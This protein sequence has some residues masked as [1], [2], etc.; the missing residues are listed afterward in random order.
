MRNLCTCQ[1][2]VAT[3]R[4]F[5][6]NRSLNYDPT[7]TLRLRKS[8]AADATRRFNKLKRDIRIS[9]IDRDCFG[10]QPE[11]IALAATP[12][13]AFDFA[14]TSDKIEGFMRWLVEQEEA[15]IL[16]I[17]RRP[18]TIR[19]IEE[20]WTDVYIQSAYAKGLVRGRTELRKQGLDIPEAEN[21]GGVR[22]LMNQ[23]FHADRVG[24]LYTRVFEDLK[25]VTQFMN[26]QI[27]RRITEG[28]TTGLAQGMAEGKNPRQIARELVKNVNDRVDKIGIT[29][30]RL[31]ARTEV[32]RA[33]HVANIAEYERAQELFDVEVEV[34][35]KAEWATAGFNVCPI[36]IDLE[37]GSPYKLHEIRG[38]IPA[39]PNCRCAALPLVIEKEAAGRRAA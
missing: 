3:K 8:F 17:I 20:A 9:I 18:G 36:C 24:V 27:R 33:H 28:L 22:A 12:Y 14:R 19:G 15:G 5:T 13:K 30:A 34:E 23:P 37:A 2:G 7:R 6:V 31:I 29:R 10:I 4:G 16:E 35:I 11:V 26:G 25:T 38:M 1:T 32:I 21:V 39:H